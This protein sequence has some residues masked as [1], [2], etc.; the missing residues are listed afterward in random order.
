MAEHR[1]HCGVPNVYWNGTTIGTVTNK[2]GEFSIAT[3]TESSDLIFSFVGFEVDS[4]WF[5][6]DL[7]MVGMR[8]VT[9]DVVEVTS[10]EK[11]TSLSLLDPI[12]TE[13]ITESE[14]LKAACCN[15]SESFETNPSVDVSFTDAVTGTRPDNHAG[16]GRTLF[17]D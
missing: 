11:S 1:M 14:L 9:L 8:E 13:L 6:G 15:L 2:Q 3:T 7:L 10:R 4:S 16:P 5:E 12:K 17:T